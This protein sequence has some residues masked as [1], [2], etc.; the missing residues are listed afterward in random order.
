MQLIRRSTRPAPTF[1]NMLDQLFNDNFFPASRKTGT[2]WN[3]SMP[4]VNVKETNDHFELELA[5]PGFEKSD[6][7]INIDKDVLTISSEQETKN[8]E[9]EENGKFTRREFSYSSFQRSFNLP[10][11]VDSEKVS[12]NYTNGILS[13]VIPKKE[14]EKPQPA[15]KIEIK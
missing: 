5:A 11:T 8:E 13:I 6:F 1:N 3:N 10:E 2:V 15:R 14:E 12:A 9:T 4:A 7:N